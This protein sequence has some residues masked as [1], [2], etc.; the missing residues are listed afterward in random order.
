MKAQDPA[1]IHYKKANKVLDNVGNRAFSD[2]R[3]ALKPQ[4]R[5]IPN[6]GH[7]GMRYVLKGFLLAPFMS[8]QST[9]LTVTVNGPDLAT[10]AALIAAGKVTP[11]IDRAYPFAEILDALGYAALGR[12]RGK[13]V[14]SVAPDGVAKGNA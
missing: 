12:A 8:Q 2:L 10:L 14:I 9:P 7:G 1:A 3:R 11:V 6:S 5:I 4:G 13:V